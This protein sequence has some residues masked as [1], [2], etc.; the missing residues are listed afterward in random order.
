[1]LIIYLGSK[2]FECGLFGVVSIM[3]LAA[4]RLQESCSFRGLGGLY[5]AVLGSE[6]QELDELGFLVVGFVKAE[7]AY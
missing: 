5:G 4:F 1:M 6:L 3:I 7:F 2:R